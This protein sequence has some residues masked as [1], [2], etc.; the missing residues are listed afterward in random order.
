M[1]KRGQVCAVTQGKKSGPVDTQVWLCPDPQGGLEQPFTPVPQCHDLYNRDS[2]SGV[3]GGCNEAMLF[4]KPVPQVITSASHST[5]QQFS[6]CSE[7]ISEQG[8]EQVF[9][10]VKDLCLCPSQTRVRVEGA[11]ANTAPQH[12]QCGAQQL[13]EALC[14]PSEGTGAIRMT[15]GPDTIFH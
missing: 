3:A 9:L 15:C 8:E 14:T 5:C 1:A 2:S 11:P 4:L 13:G 10:V 12:Q 7:A 6:L